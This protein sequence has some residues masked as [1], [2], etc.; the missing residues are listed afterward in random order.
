MALVA[1]MALNRRVL[2]VGDNLCELFADTFSDVSDKSESQFLDSD[3]DVPTASSHKQ[4]QLPTVILT[5]DSDTNTEEEEIVNRRALMCGVKLTK[6]Q[7]VVLSLEPQLRC[8]NR[9]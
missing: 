4:F 8:E 2:K 7:A 6:N 3:S 5:S 9:I 1:V